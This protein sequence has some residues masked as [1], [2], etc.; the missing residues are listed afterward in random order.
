MPALLGKGRGAVR[1]DLTPQGGHLTA[2][3]AM[4]NKHKVKKSCWQEPVQRGDG[5]EGWGYG[6]MLH[7]GLF[8]CSLIHG[9][10]TPLFFMCLQGTAESGL[11]SGSA[12]LG[13]ALCLSAPCSAALSLLPTMGETRGQGL[14]QSPST[15]TQHTPGPKCAPAVL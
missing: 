9:Q 8:L 14:L 7:L 12:D 10:T 13:A 5:P 1:G 4:G 2:R 3:A 11:P 6:L 15:T